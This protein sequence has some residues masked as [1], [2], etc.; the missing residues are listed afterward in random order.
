MPTELIKDFIG[1]ECKITMVGEQ[2][3]TTGFI[4]DVEA[5]WLKIKEKDTMR[6]INGALVR[7][8]KIIG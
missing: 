1:K 5:H 8:I 2:F 4:L 3:E 6:L 7:Y